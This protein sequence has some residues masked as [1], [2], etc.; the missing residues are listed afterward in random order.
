[1]AKVFLFMLT[2]TSALLVTHSVISAKLQAVASE[3]KVCVQPDVFKTL[4]TKKLKTCRINATQQ[5]HIAKYNLK[6]DVCMFV[7]IKN[8]LGPMLSYFC[9]KKCIIFM[10]FLFKTLLVFEKKNGS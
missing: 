1:M 2:F 6:W 8:R 4:Q 9:P 3:Q 10:R 5:V 7:Q